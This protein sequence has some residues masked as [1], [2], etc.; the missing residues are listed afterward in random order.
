MC[1]DQSD[2]WQPCWRLGQSDTAG[3]AAVQ[4]WLT[5]DR[6]WVVV[7]RTEAAPGVRQVSAP[8]VA[9]ARNHT[10]ATRS[11]HPPLPVGGGLLFLSFFFFSFGVLSLGGVARP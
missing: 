5:I 2:R 8:A 3:S 6:V 10:A 7:G 11:L 9:A 1:G 4:V